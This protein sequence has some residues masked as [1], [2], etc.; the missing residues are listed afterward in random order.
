MTSPQ[1]IIRE[2]ADPLIANGATP[3]EVRD[4]I[5]RE[6]GIGLGGGGGGSDPSIPVCAYCGAFGGGGH[7]GLCPGAS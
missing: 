6:T 1:D 4:A 3:A 7:A 2:I 5:W